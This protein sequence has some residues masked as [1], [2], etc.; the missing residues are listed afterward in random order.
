MADK[1]NTAELGKPHRRWYQFGLRTL[2]VAMVLLAAAFGYVG[3]QARIVRQRKAMLEGPEALSRA[4]RGEPEWLNNGVVMNYITASIPRG[5]EELN[6]SWVRQW[7][8]D[9]PVYVIFLDESTKV[10]DVD[11]YREMFPEAEVKTG[12]PF[13]WEMHH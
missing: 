3:H 2:L 4:G 6:L 9:F 13:A 5:R 7:L 1:T 12:D 11:R 10:K 8:G